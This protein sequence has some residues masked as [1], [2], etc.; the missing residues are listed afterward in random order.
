MC[1]PFLSFFFFPQFSLLLCW[2]CL[3]F[4]FIALSLV[5][6]HVILFLLNCKAVLFSNCPFLLVRSI[7]VSH[8]SNSKQQFPTAKALFDSQLPH[9]NSRSM[10]C[11]SH[12]QGQ[13]DNVVVDWLSS[14]VWKLS[15][16]WLTKL[17]FT[18]LNIEDRETWGYGLLWLLFVS[19]GLIMPQVILKN[20]S[21]LRVGFWS[22]IS[23]PTQGMWLIK[24]KYTHT[25]LGG[26]SPYMTHLLLRNLFAIF[27][28]L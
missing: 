24:K 3:L 11:M 2:T 26:N 14:L 9:F 5:L 20:S 8:L 22:C 15:L 18:Y 28:I 12:I 16:A 27:L 10:P 21:R 13:D 7:S 19:P 23:L 4:P 1:F 6:Q 25:F 17:L